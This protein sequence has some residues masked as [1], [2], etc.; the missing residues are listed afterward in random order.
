MVQLDVASAAAVGGERRQAAPQPF[1]FGCVDAGADA[2]GIDPLSVRTVIG[3]ELRAGIRAASFR[4]GPADHEA[5]RNP[6][7]SAAFTSRARCQADSI[8]D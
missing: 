1:K 6:N 2:A 4:C 7:N 5:D 3:G 8:M